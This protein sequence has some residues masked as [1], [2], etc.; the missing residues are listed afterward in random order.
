[1]ARFEHY[2]SRDHDMH[3]ESGRSG[4]HHDGFDR[5][6]HRD[7]AKHDDDL[8]RHDH[9]RH[10]DKHRDDF[11]RHDHHHRHSGKRRDD[12]HLDREGFEIVEPHSKAEGQTIAEWTEDWWNWALRF[13]VDENPFDDT[14]SLA[15][16]D[17]DGEVFFLA[18]TFGGTQ[19]RVIEVPEDTPILFPMLNTVES[20]PVTAQGILD[21]VEGWK[22][23]E[24]DLF[25]SIDGQP[26]RDPSRFV[27]QTDFFSLGEVQPGSLAAALFPVPVGTVL[28]PAVAVGY[29]VMIDDLEPG[30]HTLEFGGR[31]DSDSDGV[32]ED[33]DFATRVVATLNVTAAEADYPYR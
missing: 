9:H 25:A 24:K 3:P 31:F 6:D 8:G 18:G 5:Q 20:L 14:G 16:L 26:I 22:A 12:D 30:T 21:F 4:K 11:D 13:P 23:A 15:H 32:L 10:S 7:F 28:E 27:E 19:A 17:N 1:M 33:T 29:W 2:G